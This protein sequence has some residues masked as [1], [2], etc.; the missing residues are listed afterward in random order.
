MSLRAR[1][2]AAI[3]LVLAISLGVGV[4]FA[5]L[6]GRLSLR[7]ELA[8]G[9]SGGRQT[10]QTALAEEPRPTDGALRELVATFDGNRHVSAALVGADGRVRAA[11][12]PFPS[13]HPAPTWF[14]TLLDPRLPAATVPLPAPTADF[15]SIRLT[16]APQDDVS[17]VWLQFCNVVAVVAFA[18]AAAFGLIYV[19]IGRALQPLRALSSGFTRVGSGDYRVRVEETGPPEVSSLASAFNRMAGDLSAMQAKNQALED[20]LTRLQDEERADLARDLHDEIGPHLFAV[21]VDAAMIAQLAERGRTGEIAD[22]VKSIQGGV[23]HMQKLVRDIL[24]RLRPAAVTELGFAAA[25]DDLAAFWR[26]RQ[27]DI[28]FDVDVRID[29]AALSQAALETVYRVVQE[30]LSNAVRHGGPTRVA[31]SVEL[32]GDAASARVRDDGAGAAGA[33]TK[34]GFGLA[35]MRERVEALG[36]ALSVG[37]R[38]EGGWEVAARI[39]AAARAAGA[40]RAA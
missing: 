16:A 4:V 35:G 11:S 18:C 5:S 40:A 36:G 19:T 38:S 28:A 6:V 21:N 39:P 29:E 3:A 32:E 23:A 37:P 26:E 27:P 20:Q 8:A 13:G 2:L 12:R 33:G 17:D 25:V 9:M 15:A 24:S 14:S 31:V 1:V 7:D 22:Q 34:P 10:V 30:G